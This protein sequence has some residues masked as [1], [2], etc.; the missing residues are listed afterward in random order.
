MELSKLKEQAFEIIRKQE[1]LRFQYAE[2][3]EQRK[4]LIKKI[5]ELEKKDK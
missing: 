4:T 5:D 3:D 1:I 2:L